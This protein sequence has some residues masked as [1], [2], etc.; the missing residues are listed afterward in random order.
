MKIFAKLKEIGWSILVSTLVIAVLLAAATASPQTLEQLRYGASFWQLDAAVDTPD[1]DEGSLYVY[2]DANTMTLYFKDDQG[3]ATSL[4]AGAAADTLDSAYT[5]GSTITGDASGDIE[6]DLSVTARKVII[7][8]TFA[9][10]QAVGLEIDAEAGSQAVTDAL[11][12]NTSGS[13]ATIIDAID[14]SDAGITNALNVGDNIIIGAAGVI[15]FTEFDVS[16][17]TG[18]VV[19]DDDGDLGSI[20]I[21]GTGLDINSLD[22]VVAGAITAAESSAITINPHSGDAAGEDLILTAH[23]LQLTAAGKLTLSPDEAETLAIDLTDGNYTN[24]L[25]VAANAILGTT[26][27]IDYEYF[28]VDAVGAVDCTALNAGAGTIETT[29]DITCGGTISAT[30]IAQDAI[31]AATGDTTLTLDG[32]GTGGVGIGTAS[33]D[34]AITL[35]GS[36]TTVN[37]PATVDMTLAGGDLSIT[38]TAEGDLVTLVNDALTTSDILDISAAGT[39][40]SGNVIKI[41]D[42][43]TTAGT[44]SIVAD[45][46]TTANIL[47]IQADALEAGGAMIYLDSAGIPDTSTYYIE[48]AGTGTDFTVAKD[49]VMTMSG[50][51]DTDVI[52]VTTGDVQVDDGKLEINTDEDDTTYIERAQAAVTGAVLSLVE[53]TD[54]VASGKAVLFIDQ[55]TDSTP[56]SAIEIDTEGAY[57]MKVD[58][59]V[60]AG[61]GIYLDVADSYAGQWFITDAGPWLGTIGEGFWSFTTDSAATQEVGQVI[62]INLQ[63]EGTAGTEVHGKALYA[64][65]QAAV[66]TG[67]SLIYLD[68]LT[69]TAIHIDNEGAAADGINF[70]VAGSYTGQGIVADLGTWLGVAGEGFIDID[71]DGAARA[72]EGHV[73]HINL[74]GTTADAA[75][76]SGKGLYIKDAAGATANSYLI[77]AESD[78]NGAAYFDGDIDVKLPNNDD[79]LSIVANAADYAA[80]SGIITVYDDSA[81]QTNVMYLLRLATEATADA[82][83]GFILCQDNSDGT[84]GNGAGK[85]T[86]SYDGA[87]VQEGS[88][89]V[90][91][92]QIIGD[93]A[94]ELVGVKHDVVD[95]LSANPYTVTIAMSGT[96]FYNSEASEFDLPEASTAIGCWYTF[97]V[98]HIS[99]LY[100][101]PEAS[102][103]ILGA[104][105]SAGDRI[106]SSTVGDTVTI[107]CIDGTNWVVKST[108]PASTDWP[109]ADA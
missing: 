33:G 11:K 81:G 72:E 52:T 4:I 17:T 63:G 104:T 43:A 21:E 85:Y 25:S 7:A 78:N 90:N 83:N 80:G 9:G 44:I 102:D 53:Q 48:C 24:A 18:A 32:K 109:D 46:V 10:T 38:D 16:G 8:N 51:A 5:A 100:I 82:Q 69:N 87:V 96:T 28:D 99:E 57:V 35:G 70:D 76:I 31:V 26:G 23:N 98:A 27:L 20:T 73:I 79:F 12:F 56:S 6:I 49:G 41:V 61:D 94:T 89:T 1:T 42:G 92:A 66:K 19:I 55:D 30:A 75:A 107:E 3:T 47:A 40:L 50:V 2:D 71:S 88:L 67:E 58:A 34:G 22:F 108:Y 93:G 29:G 62:R 39:R 68:T 86:V 106:H 15:N 60:A 65:S 103:K 37:L 14:A 54:T 95:A 13:G 97:A 105:D 45:S 101:D 36:A 64:H 77:H 59:L 74:G 84:A 91:G